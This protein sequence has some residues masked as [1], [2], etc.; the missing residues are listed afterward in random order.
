MVG[1]RT[2]L[3]AFGLA[4]AT[5]FSRAKTIHNLSPTVINGTSVANFTSAAT[6]LNGPQISAINGSAY[7]LWYFDVVSTDPTSSAS[8]VV[9]F[10]NTAPNAFP[11]VAADNTTLIASLVIT[12]PNG[13][14]SSAGVASM[15]ADSAT[16]TVEGNGASGDWH[17]TGMSWKYYPTSGAYDVLIDSPALDVKGSIH[18]APVS[19]ASQPMQ[20]RAPANR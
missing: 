4:F 16:V 15:L 18:F 1:I 14:I 19:S 12:F 6:G 9:I 17:G 13:T 2:A 3:L 20:D 8:V 5:H 7:D 10:Y 11:F